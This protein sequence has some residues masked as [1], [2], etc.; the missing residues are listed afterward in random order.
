MTVARSVAEIL[1]DRVSLEVES[2]DR[3]FCNLYVPQLQHVNGVVQFFRGHRG[4]PFA[5]SALMDPISKDFV[6]SIH[7]FCRDQDVPMVEFVKGQRKDDVAHE[8]LAGF[9]GEEGVLFVGRAQEKTRVFR[10]EKR[11][12]RDTGATYPWIVSATGVVNQFY[13]YA[14]DAEF[15]PFFIKFCSYFPYTAK[16]CINGNEYAKRVAAK[17]GIGFTALDNGFATCEDPRRLQRICDR[18]SPAKIDALVRKWLRRLPHPFTAADRAA[19]HPLRHLHP[20]GGVLVDPGAGPAGHRTG[21]LRRGH[22]G[23]PR[24]GPSG[25]G[26]VGLRPAHRHQRPAQDP[27]PVPYPGPDC[28]RDSQPAHRLQE[29]QGQAVP[30]AGPGPTY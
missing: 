16:L 28:R 20:A 29:H 1:A 12:N 22:P 7:R 30:Q 10:T 27:G 25:P 8:Y 9:T 26:G 2:I 17:A 15:G 24:P 23:K 19:G 6:A 3:M 13:V 14:V 5:S 18:L 11:R 4:Q 21:L